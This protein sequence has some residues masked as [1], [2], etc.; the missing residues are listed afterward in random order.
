MI[1]KLILILAVVFLVSIPVSAQENT[2]LYHN[3][4]GDFIGE[5]GIDFEDIKNYP[6]ETLWDTVKQ[7]VKKGLTS[8]LKIFA[9][10]TALLIITSFINLFSS[11]SSDKVSDIVNIVCV[12]VLFSNIYDSFITLFDS[13]SQNM[14]QIKNF[15]VSFLPVFA[16]I[17]FAAGEMIT[18]TVY[19]GLFMLSVVATANVCL[20]YIIPSLKLFVAVGITS[21]LSSAINLK[22]LCSFYSRVLKISMTV[23][24]SVLC[25]ILTLQTTITQGQDNLA[26]KTGKFIISSAVP[27]IGSALQSAVGSVYASMGVLKGFFGIAGITVI[28]ALFVPS[29]VN[30]AVN[31]AGYSLMAVL[32]E[33]LENKTAADVINIFKDVTE[34]LISLSVLFMI[35]LVFSLTVMIKVGQ[36]V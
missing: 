20:V 29:I 11:S 19:T 12:L 34:I 13:V 25:F 17:S 21:S 7:S 1:K 5:Y 15:M 14:F 36:A 4:A 32:S 18:S 33:M 27:V 2:N 31:W 6:F 26:V 24:V 22:P 3:K 23:A 35:L 30:L 8:P 10:I 9:K 28:S 16:G